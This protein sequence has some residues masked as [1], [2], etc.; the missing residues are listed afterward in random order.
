[1]PVN[2]KN[3]IIFFF[4]LLLIILASGCV[5]SSEDQVKA[6]FACTALSSQ[7]F[8]WVPAC[9]NQTVC[10]QKAHKELFGFDYSIFS[11]ESRQSIDRYQNALA[12][13][14]LYFNKSQDDLK[15]IQT[16]CGSATDFSALPPLINQLNQDLHQAFLATDESSQNAF[17]VVLLLKNELQKDQ[18]DLV[19]EEKLFSNW[20]KLQETANSLQNHSASNPASFAGRLFESQRRMAELTEQYGIGPK[21]VSAQNL[22]DLIPAH[23][24]E[25]LDQL[26][27]NQPFFPVLG[28]MAIDLA[29]KFSQQQTADNSIAGLQTFP[30]YAFFGVF[31]EINGT[32]NSIA[33]ELSQ[34]ATDTAKNK[35]ELMEQNRELSQK[36]KAELGKTEE[37]LTELQSSPNGFESQTDFLDLISELPLQ[38]GFAPQGFEINDVSHAIPALIEK[39]NGLFRDLIRLEQD[40]VL[41]K[42]TLGAQTKLLKELS[43]GLLALNDNTD[44]FQNRLGNGLSELCGARLLD[45]QKEM[46]KMNLASES[47]IELAAKTRFFSGE[48]KKTDAIFEKLS[49]CKN[50]IQSFNDLAGYRQDQAAFEAKKNQEFGECGRFL[51][52]VFEK[53]P[54]ELADLEQQWSLIR[55]NPSAW[56]ATQT[57]NECSRIKTQ[58]ILR[59]AQNPLFQSL[60]A[61][62]TL[63]KSFFLGI[64]T[65]NSYLKTPVPTAEL[66]N[67]FEKLLPAFDGDQKIIEEIIANQSKVENGVADFLDLSQ[68]RFSEALIAE[69]EQTVQIQTTAEQ[70]IIANQAQTVSHRIVF[71]NPTTIAWNEPVALDIAA[72]FSNPAILQKSGNVDGVQSIGKQTRIRLST[73]PSGVTDLT[74]LSEFGATTIEEDSFFSPTEYS[75]WSQKK[76]VIQTPSTIGRLQVQAD[77]GQLPVNS[78][79]VLYGRT[80][81]PFELQNQ[82]IKF[83]LANVSPNAFVTVFFVIQNPLSVQLQTEF[84]EQS[85]QI[86]GTIQNRLAAELKGVQIKIPVPT[87]FFENVKAEV[88]GKKVSVDELGDEWR[89]KILVLKEKQVVELHALAFTDQA[90]DVVKEMVIQT[91][92]ALEQLGFDSNP[93]IK[94]KAAELLS[95]LL[96]ISDFSTQAASKT[97]FEIARKTQELLELQKQNGFSSSEYQKVR[98]NAENRIANLEQHTVP[99]LNQAGFSNAASIVQAQIREALQWLIRAQIAFENNNFASAV[100][101]ALKALNALNMADAKLG[102]EFENPLKDL[103][104]Q[105]KHVMEDLQKNNP[106]LQSAQAQKT[107]SDALSRLQ[108]AVFGGNPDEIVLALSDAKQ[109]IEQAKRQTGEL[110]AQQLQ[111]QKKSIANTLQKIESADLSSRI[112]KLITELGQFD[113]GELVKS[114][115]LLSLSKADLQKLQSESE[116]LFS[117]KEWEE[118]RGFLESNSSA[119]GL[120]EKTLDEKIS[121]F[122]EIERQVGQF[123]SLLRQNAGIE[124]EKAKEIASQNGLDSRQTKSLFDAENAFE[125]KDYLSAWYYAKKITLSKQSATGLISLPANI[126]PVIYPIIGVILIGGFLKLRKKKNPENEAAKSTKIRIERVKNE[127]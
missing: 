1:M 115:I 60:K 13:S 68:K 51:D 58:L 88:D 80:E 45:I 21:L 102:A 126:P 8:A 31:S 56:S 28:N 35:R 93:A 91:R 42:T 48:Y 110:N 59:F 5:F 116:K 70:T 111:K 40:V 72:A 119:T 22:I 52:A 105:G 44:F 32:E 107:V 6:R 18:L 90:A 15:K 65:L 33:R 11:L 120:T 86:Q 39:R 55:Q 12:K 34:M 127:L 121:R 114:G 103:Q 87:R 37:R 53:H 25:L 69:L 10:F 66:K 54:A 30:I 50:A 79:V 97:V 49:N 104:K 20:V 101:F 100:T 14:W 24:K 47:E 9:D 117:K 27:K 123:E 36:I 106:S 75:V 96:N 113:S 94:T 46:A 122:N 92:Q 67:R 109:A 73:I 78:V 125:N 19:K 124:V 4:A 7:S 57:Q 77:L 16:A 3:G 41:N 61:D 118:L 64:Q 98:E 84:S 99:A 38:T 112:K 43:Q 63:A 71:F 81:I 26:P 95:Q 76:I 89:I 23:Q 17:A 2:P 83:E 74:I 85:L 29:K 62:F 82:R 108:L